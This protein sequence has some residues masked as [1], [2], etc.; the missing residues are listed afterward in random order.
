MRERGVT[1]GNDGQCHHLHW[2]SLM[3]LQLWTL[4]L[5]FYQMDGIKYGA[6]LFGD[7]L[8]TLNISCVLRELL[9]L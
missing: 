2:S 3:P 6:I 4:H 1:V 7:C 8:S 5:P 9:H